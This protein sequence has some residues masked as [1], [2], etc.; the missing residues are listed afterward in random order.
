MTAFVIIALYLLVL[1]GLGVASNRLLRR[2]QDDYFLASRGVGSFLL[3]M[4]LFGTTM[5][6]FAM[7]GS[8]GESFQTGIGVYG[9]MAS[10]SG[11]VHALCFFVIGVKLWSFGKRFGYVTQIQFFRDRFESSRIG[12][13]LFPVL[14]GMM[15]PY[16]LLG[17]LGLGTVM[18]RSTEGAFPTLF[19]ATRGGIPDW[20]GMGVVCGVVLIYVFVGGVR[21]T[22]WINAFQNILFLTVGLWTIFVIADKLGGPAEATRMVAERNPSLLK[23]TFDP[24][25]RAAFDAKL[26]THEQSMAA[27]SAGPK[28]GRPPRKP[29][30]P[31]IGQLEFLSYGL[32]PLSVAMF[33]HLFAYYLT[34]RTAKSFRLSVVMHPIFVLML[35]LPCVMLGVWASSAVVNGQL[36]LPPGIEPNGVLAAFVRRMTGDVLGGLMAA[37]IM[38]TNSL[39]A[40]F[41]CLGAMFTNDIVAH[42]YGREKFTD[43]Q[44]VFIGRMFVVAIVVVTYLLSL[45][46]PASVFRLGIWCFSG[47]AGLTPLLIAAIYWPRVT[48][49]GAYASIAAAAA[50]WAWLFAASGYGRDEHFLVWGM[51]PVAPIVL[52][53]TI[54]MIAVSLI[55]RPPSS[56]T[57]S[58]FFP[59]R[60]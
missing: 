24:R 14:V 17:V 30:P 22:L 58:R 37:S 2:T 21:S 19:P 3:F 47:Y 56:E 52:V 42:H 35:W 9:M 5:T 27:W 15:I 54:A 10:W 41:L 60:A 59:S 46:H 57:L 1:I 33:P 44:L 32:I 7:V 8:S 48:K 11:I 53:A 23:R 50:A 16:V 55:T 38:A 29:V 18:T 31:G 39:D 49:A 25:D 12:L 40:Q 13:L 45:L 51:N 28:T 43:R 20:L 36:V 6:S 34:A 4:S 26:K